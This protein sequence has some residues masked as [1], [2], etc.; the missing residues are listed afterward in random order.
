MPNM[1]SCLDS[2]GTISMFLSYWQIASVDSARSLY[3]NVSFH[4]LSIVGWGGGGGG[5]KFQ[6]TPAIGRLER[7]R[8]MSAYTFVRE[9][10]FHCCTPVML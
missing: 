8:I 10:R 9:Y 3:A 4:T 2:T 6:G 7:A 5:N 1:Q